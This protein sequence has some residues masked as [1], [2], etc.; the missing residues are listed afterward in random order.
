MR[1]IQSERV[2]PEEDA[3]PTAFL[4]T[5]VGTQAAIRF[6]ERISKLDLTPPQ[7]GIIFILASNDG[8]NQRFLAYR[9]GVVPS[10]LVVLLDKLE[11]AGLIER[12]ATE[13]RTTHA[14]HLTANGQ[15]CLKIVGKASREHNESFLASLSEVEKAQLRPILQKIA[16]HEGLTEGVHPGYKLLGCRPKK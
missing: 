7:V 13:R 4:L 14:I 15:E 5:Q 2:Q 16:D 3:P 8:V 10:R 1:K 9:L 12:R 11:S 6:A